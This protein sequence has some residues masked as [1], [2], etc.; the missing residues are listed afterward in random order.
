MQDSENILW[1]MSKP[2]P[3]VER[4]LLQQWKSIQEAENGSTAA[5]L[6]LY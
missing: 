1:D 3:S 6:E 2:T 5:L 4:K